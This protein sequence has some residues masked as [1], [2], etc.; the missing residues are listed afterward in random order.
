MMRTI[1]NLRQDLYS[2]DSIYILI[3]WNVGHNTGTAI[4]I[5]EKELRMSLITQVKGNTS[6]SRKHL[7]REHVADPHFEI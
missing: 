4:R 3:I 1:L 7:H 6:K 2:T 5:V